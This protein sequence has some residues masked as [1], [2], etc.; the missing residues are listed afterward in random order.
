MQMDLSNDTTG[1]FM[2]YIN[3]RESE[4][5]FNYY[6][7]ELAKLLIPVIESIE[8]NPGS[9]DNASEIVETYKKMMDVNPYNNQ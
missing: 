5:M 4:T 6:A 8:A 9:L 1:S 2:D 7:K 3:R